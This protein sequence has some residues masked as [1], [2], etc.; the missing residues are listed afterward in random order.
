MPAA[1]RKVLVTVLFAFIYTSAFG[2]EARK[3]KTVLVSSTEV[4]KEDLYLSGDTVIV[5]GTVDGDIWSACR[6]LEVHGSVEGSIFAVGGDIM[7]AGDVKNGVKVIGGTLAITGS[8]GNDLF[9]LGK[10]VSVVSNA[11]VDGDLFF[12]AGEALIEGPIGGNVRGAAKTVIIGNRVQENVLLYVNYL[13]LLEGAHIGGNL[14]YT[15][16]KE[17]LVKPGASIDGATTRH[18]PE[19]RRRIR[20]IFPFIVLATVVGKVFVFLMTALVGLV[21]TLTAPN[22]FFLLSEGIRKKPGA[23]AGWGALILFGVP[24]GAAIA[25]GTVVGIGIGT[26]AASAYIIALYIG[27]I[28]ISLCLGRTILGQSVEI[29]RRGA[30]FGS[31]ILGLFI[32]TLL[33]LVPVLGYFVWLVASLFGVGSIVTALLMRKQ[34]SMKK[35]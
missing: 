17:A 19:Y 9:F 28:A 6:S 3:G 35:A 4:V 33:K 13:T 5:E 2:L 21:F 31:F 1:V 22:A 16:D 18:V 15:S 27:H 20:E 23:S 25:F 11:A 10:E 30:I 29:E 34:G 8:I 26:V 12:G 7:I 14:T 24:I 32:I